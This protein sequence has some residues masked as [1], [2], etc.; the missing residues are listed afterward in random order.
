MTA[1]VVATD[2]DLVW[3]VGGGPNVYE[4]QMQIESNVLWAYRVLRRLP[5]QRTIDIWFDDG[6]DPAPDVTEWSPPAE[7]PAT[8]QPLARVLDSYRN[9]GERYRNHHIPGPVHSTELNQLKADLK[10][11]LGALRP[12]QTVWLIFNGHGS[13]RD[14]HNNSIALWNNTALQVD[15]LMRLLRP[16][17]SKTRLRFLFTQCYSGSFTRLATPASDRCGFVA[18]AADREAEGCSAA[19]DEDGWQDYSTHFFAALGGRQR[20]GSDLPQDPDQNGDGQV[21]PLEAHYYTLVMADSADI[22][23]ATSEALLEDW[24]PWYLSMIP[25]TTEGDNPYGRLAQALMQRAGITT[26]AERRMRRRTLQVEQSHLQQIRFQLNGQLDRLRQTMEQDLVRR[27]PGIGNAY[28]L[29]YKWFLE[30]NLNTAQSYIVSQPSYAELKDLQDR[31]WTLAEQAL[32]TERVLTRLDKIDH[33]LRLARIYAALQRF[34]PAD[35][36]AR[37]A[38]LIACESAPF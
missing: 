6:N 19:L 13:L 15:E 9:N 11:A 16:V 18:E 35:I 29:N 33:L 34:G 30:R 21:S 22:P 24:H 1:R 3:L 31:S 36:K 4:S 26:D 27:W 8:L 25:L 2:H 20:D 5:G 12:S 28:T 32:R 14:D 7:T 37:Y 23:R 17:P 38:Q 10:M